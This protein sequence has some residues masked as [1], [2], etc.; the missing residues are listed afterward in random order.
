M[1]SLLHFLPVVLLLNFNLP[2]LLL[3]VKQALGRQISLFFPQIGDS[4]DVGLDSLNFDFQVN[5]PVF[6]G[7]LLGLGGQLPLV[8]VLLDVALLVFEL[9]LGLPLEVRQVLFL[10]PEFLAS[11][12]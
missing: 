8:N 5:D 2:Y 11:E 9:S 1:F 3:Q 12:L 7:P 6:E 10:L 4:L